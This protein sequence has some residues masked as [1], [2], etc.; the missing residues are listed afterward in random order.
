MRT[1]LWR[2]RGTLCTAWHYP[3]SLLACGNTSI[4][5]CIRTCLT[6][7]SPHCTMLAPSRTAQN[8]P[9]CSIGGAMA[10]RS[11]IAYMQGCTLLYAT[12]SVDNRCSG[13]AQVNRRTSLA[14]LSPDAARASKTWLLHNGHS[15]CPQRHTHVCT[16]TS[17]LKATRRPADTRAAAM[18]AWS[19]SLV[20]MIGAVGPFSFITHPDRRPVADHRG[21]SATHAGGGC[22]HPAV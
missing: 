20:M 4:E 17:M 10:V 5:G 9:A 8:N 12:A 13:L 7:L 16:H 14:V 18:M 2:H 1:S 15:A 11:R 6:H 19:L 21:V 22:V 3:A